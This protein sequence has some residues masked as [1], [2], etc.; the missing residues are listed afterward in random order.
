MVKSGKRSSSAVE[1][2]L[3]RIRELIDSKGYARAV[4]IALS[5]GISQASVTKMV[6][7]LDAEGLVKH[8][9]YRGLILTEEGRAIAMAVSDRHR[10]LTEF[11]TLLGISEPEVERDVEGMEH[12]LSSSSLEAIEVLCRELNLNREFLE[13]IRTGMKQPLRSDT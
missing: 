12:H 4:D 11:L 9:R 3:E 5:L 13:R 7:R 6:K 10:I 1:D 2:Y 8:E